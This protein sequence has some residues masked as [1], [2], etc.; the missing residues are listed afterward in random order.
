[1]LH[2]QRHVFLCQIEHIKDDRL[3]ASVLT[4]VD[5]VHHLYDGLALMH[6]LLFAILSDNSQFALYQHTLVHDGMVVP[7]QLL[8]CRKFIF[9]SHQF[10]TTLQ[11]VGQLYAVPAL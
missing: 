4:V 6:N 11:I 5:G 3:R 1:M 10:R 8:S 7:A 2:S 9:Y